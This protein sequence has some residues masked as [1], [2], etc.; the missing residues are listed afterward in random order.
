MATQYKNHD[1]KAWI[2]LG[3]KAI[4]QSA[5]GNCNRKRQFSYLFH[6]TNKTKELFLKM[7]QK[8]LKNSKQ[9]ISIMLKQERLRESL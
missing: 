5:L 9:P 4:L 6:S 2:D 3:C 8:S 1:L 7:I